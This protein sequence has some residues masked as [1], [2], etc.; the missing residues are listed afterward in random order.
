MREECDCFLL[1]VLTGVLAVAA[2]I[3]RASLVQPAARVW[4]ALSAVHAPVVVED[5]PLPPEVVTPAVLAAR[6]ART[7]F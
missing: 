1:G 3:A 6:R 7:G 5:A 2:V 4:A